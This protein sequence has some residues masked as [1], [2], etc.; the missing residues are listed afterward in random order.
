[1]APHDLEAQWNLEAYWAARRKVMLDTMHRA[2]E[3]RRETAGLTLEE[4][5]ERAS[6]DFDDALWR[7]AQ[8]RYAQ[9]QR[10]TERLA[11]RFQEATR[12]RRDY[13][14]DWRVQVCAVPDCTRNC[15][16]RIDFCEECGA[17]VTHEILTGMARIAA[18]LHQRD[19]EADGT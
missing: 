7:E 19:M 14:A 5:L 1:M 2:A 8:R 11:R 18:E 9:H 6:T 10:D 4:V 13:W 16:P 3:V 12:A 15:A 17:Q